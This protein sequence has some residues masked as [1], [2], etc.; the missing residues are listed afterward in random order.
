[1]IRERIEDAVDVGVFR[2]P[3]PPLAKERVGGTRRGNV[4]AGRSDSRCPGLP[5][6]RDR[7]AAE[8][9]LELDLVGTLALEIRHRD[10]QIEERQ[11]ARAKERVVDERRERARRVERDDPEQRF[12]SPAMVRRVDVEELGEKRLSRGCR[13]IDRPVDERAAE[14]RRQNASGRA[15]RTHREDRRRAV[16]A[17]ALDL[18]ELETR[19]EVRRPRNQLDRESA[20]LTHCRQPCLPVGRKAERKV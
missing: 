3:S 15:R 10:R 11:V 9:R 14:E 20:R 13:A 8:G 4:L 6:L 12:G 2:A 1:M 16:G 7:E 5:R 18:R 19:A 17:P